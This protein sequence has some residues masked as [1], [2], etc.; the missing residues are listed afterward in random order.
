MAP[1]DRRRFLQLAGATAATSALMGTIDKAA[2]M[3]ANHR[4]GSLRDVEHVVILMQENRSFDHYF[5]S[6]RGVRGFG[7]PTPATLPNGKSVWHQPE[8]TGEVLPFHPSKEQLGLAFLEDLDHSW[9]GGHLAFNGGNYDRWIPAKTPTTMAYLTRED[10]PFHYALADAFTI[11]DQYHCSLLG[12]TDPNRYY[13]WSG[14]VGND[15]KGGGPVISNDEQGYS[16]TTY[17]E[18]LEK[19]GVSWKIYQDIGTGLDSDGSWGWAGDPYIGN[20]GDNSL[21]YFDQYRT[22]AAGSALYEKARTGT[23]VAAGGGYF[24]Q[25]RADVTNG[26]LPQV[27]WIVA[28][29]AFTE[30]P[31][32]PANY[33]AWYVSQI[34]DALT[35]DPQVWARTAL[36][37][38]YDEN[39]GFFDHIV[40]PHSPVSPEHGGSTV[41]TTNERF[42]GSSEGPAG[43]Y[44]MGQRVPMLVVSPWS[45]GGFVCSDVLDHTSIIRFL[46]QRFEVP[47]PNITPWRRSVAGDLLAAFDFSRGSVGVPALPS[48]SGYQPPDKTRHPDYVPSPPAEQ[49]VPRQEPGT[50]P[51]RPLGY[52]VETDD[53]ATPGTLS[54]QVRNTASRGVALQIR[55]TTDLTGPWSYTIGA[56]QDLRIALHPLTSCYDYEAHGPNG[57]F[58]AWRG[59]NVA[60]NPSV[61]TGVSGHRLTVTVQNPGA[62]TTITSVWGVRR[63][64][65][66]THALRHGKEWTF[67]VDAGP[68]HGWYDVTVTSSADPHFRRRLR[69]HLE[70]GRASASD[71]ALG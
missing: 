42:A 40:P 60:V 14:W 44:G 49:S 15:G 2:A 37:I 22:A 11:C 58:R 39:D 69:G 25:F 5:G 12:P 66:R 27:S 59:G 6:L 46:E 18:R 38:T 34:L 56:R 67:E 33:G 35:A 7:D 32:W 61:T 13:M 45:K 71:P 16:W 26:K 48:T 10:I 8:L 51:A 24:D 28:P 47:E 52:Q 62:D 20:Y 53:R 31:N 50:R 54:L 29:E 9:T 19:V 41:P 30:H 68:D 21:L 55:S 57:F 65:T 3:P 70:D 1:L 64:T 4:T 17:P 43:P 36:F 23:N 63:S